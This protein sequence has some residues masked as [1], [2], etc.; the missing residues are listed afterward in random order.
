MVSAS[1][2]YVVLFAGLTIAAVGLCLEIA[3]GMG[4]YLVG[5]VRCAHGPRATRLWLPLVSCDGRPTC[6]LPLSLWVSG[7]ELRVRCGGLHVLCAVP[8]RQ[9]V[10]VCYYETHAWF[11]GP[12]VAIVSRDDGEAA[13]E[14]IVLS[15]SPFVPMV[16]TWERLRALGLPAE[17]ADRGPKWPSPPLAS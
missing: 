10:A 17:R 3:S 8:L 13:V 5:R 15:T 7:D 1:A 4:R 6:A 11:A 9:V 12:C 16:Q 14:T 2:A